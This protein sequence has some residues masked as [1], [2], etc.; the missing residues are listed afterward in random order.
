MTHGKRGARLIGE[1]ALGQ[2]MGAGTDSILSG[3]G[4]SR[5]KQGRLLT[6]GAVRRMRGPAEE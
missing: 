1:Q 2:V 4:R 6:R 3:R 5:T